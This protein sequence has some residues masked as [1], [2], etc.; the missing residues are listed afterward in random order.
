[1]FEFGIAACQFF[2]ADLIVF[3]L[4]IDTTRQIV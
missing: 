3:A 2:D 1:L 4:R